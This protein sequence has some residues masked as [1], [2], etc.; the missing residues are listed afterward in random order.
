MFDQVLTSRLAS[1][2][3]R[4]A[5]G[6][7]NPL[8][9]TGY[10][11]VANT[12]GTTAIGVV[13]WVVAA[14]LY[15]RQVVGRYSA[16]VSALIAVSSMAQIDLTNT[17]PRFMPH[18]GRSVGRFIGYGYAASSLAAVIIGVGFVTVLPRLSTQYHFISAS[19]GLA[20]TFVVAAVVWGIFAL[21]DA[22]L[23]G[24][25]RAVVV[26]VENS[27]YGVLKLLLLV[28]VVTLLP[29]T[30]IFVAWLA[31]LVVIVPVINWLIFRRYIRE[32]K[33]VSAARLRAREIVRFASV[34]YLGM[35]FSQA[36][37]YLLPVLVL[38]VLG[39]AANGSFFV[40][41]T[42]AA[43]LELLAVNFGMSLLVEGARAPHRLAELTRGVLVR[44]AVVTIP[45][46]VVLAL[47]APL[48]LRIY[49]SAYAANAS[50][51]LRLLGAGTVPTSVV[52][53]ALTLDRIERRVGRAAV[54]QLALAVLVVVG[55][56]L[57]MRK[58]G[59]DGVGLAWLG[60]SA[61]I[62]AARLP[63]ILRVLARPAAVPEL[64]P[65]A[66]Q[67][68]AAPE[69]GMMPD[70]VVQAA[71]VSDQE[72]T[73]P[74]LDADKDQPSGKRTGN[75]LD[76]LAAVVAAVLLIVVSLD[77]PGVFRTLLTLGFAFFVPGRAIVSNWPWMT[78][79]SGAAMSVVF[80]LV[81]L[82][83]LATVSLWAQLWHP[84]ALFQAEAWL[85][86]AGLGLGWA[87]RHRNGRMR[88]GRHRNGRMRP[89]RHRNGRMRPDSAEALGRGRA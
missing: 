31:P 71:R 16:L 37:G 13:Y 79:W 1:V 33:P 83:L 10:A 55:S 18:A 42:I 62:A 58:H 68:V 28:S 56:V 88:P 6:L 57:L 38:G 35:L 25:R 61:V 4:I 66:V 27:V 82:T 12:V 41:W 60:S 81:A 49:G 5:D 14:H 34:D 75:A 78:R 3:C 32:W 87:R 15:N 24:L 8:Y 63:T 26:P 39:P 80:S 7:R 45:G 76:L 73:V 21:E 40:A 36:Y 52:V 74:G 59:I 70:P 89:G 48:I 11:L 65:G 50:T 43:G 85:S 9:R 30:G 69:A 53:V 46:A 67:L 84:L 44:C 29:S 47:A 2:S 64:E 51:L 22:A 17:M 19:L 86:L 54:S 23:T 72:I 77:R 20:V